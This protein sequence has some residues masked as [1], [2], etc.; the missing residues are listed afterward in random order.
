MY[1]T[2]THSA[3]IT[4]RPISEV[5]AMLRNGMTPVMLKAKIAKKIVVRRATY[6]PAF[7]LPMMS[8]ATLT[9]TK[10]SRSSAM[11]WPRLGTRRARRAAITMT[12]SSTATATKRT[13]WMRLISKIVPSNQMGGGKN[14]AI[15]GLWNPDSPSAAS[16]RIV[17]RLD[18]AVS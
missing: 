16:G 10:S 11:F 15:D 7:S 3:S 9:R 14:S 1:M 2:Y 5:P 18:R 4:G 8:S 13:T 12:V 6:F 17:A